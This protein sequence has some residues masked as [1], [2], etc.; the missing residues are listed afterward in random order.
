MPYL[1]VL[2]ACAQATAF[3]NS[4]KQNCFIPCLTL[5][6]RAASGLEIFPKNHRFYFFKRIIALFKG[7]SNYVLPPPLLFFFHHTSNQMTGGKSVSSGREKDSYGK[8]LDVASSW[9]SCIDPSGTGRWSHI[10]FSCWLVV[11]IPRR[12]RLQRHQF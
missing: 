3:R 4:Q 10:L 6:T 8:G 1:G 7:F 2:R 5:V 9:H 11:G 12:K